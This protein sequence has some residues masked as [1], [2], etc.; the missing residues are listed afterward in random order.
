MP[1]HLDEEI[2]PLSAASK[3][4]PGRPHEA[5]VRRWAKGIGGCQLETIRCGKRIYTSRQ[6]VERFLAALNSNPK[7]NPIG[8]AA[9][10]AAE[11]SL[12]ANGFFGRSAEKS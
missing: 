12:R 11:D 8:S 5:S 10:Q 7:A 2:I 1:V 3:I 6:A 9:P 4:L